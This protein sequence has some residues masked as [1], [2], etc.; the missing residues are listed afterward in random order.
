MTSLEAVLALHKRFD[1]IEGRLE[2]V[3][4]RQDDTEAKVTT[5]EHEM[6]LLKNENRTLQLTT[7]RIQAD[8][9]KNFL[10]L[11]GLPESTPEEVKAKAEE[12]I[13]V[14]LRLPQITP[15]EC[16]KF[17][18]APTDNSKVRPTSVHFAHINEREAVFSAS[19]KI[20]HP[21]IAV[22]TDRPKILRDEANKRRAARPQ[23]QPGHS[24]QPK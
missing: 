9:R 7:A 18:N 20:N 22:Y 23:R 1:A 19:R 3:E 6:K 8:S 5:L 21:T 17:G 24:S 15:D 11:H 16:R 12:Y 4:S 2:V 14:T 10:I 13:H